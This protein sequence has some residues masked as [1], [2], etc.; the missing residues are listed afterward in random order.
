MSPDIAEIIQYETQNNIEC[1]FDEIEQRVNSCR[2]CD[3]LRFEGDVTKCA[4]TGCDIGLM[5]TMK[6]QICPK[7]NW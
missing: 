7:G 5:T 6:I 3:L 4:N 2:V 1:S